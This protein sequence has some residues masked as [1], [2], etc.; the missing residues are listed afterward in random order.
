MLDLE[1]FKKSLDEDLANPN[2]YW[3]TIKRKEAVKERWIEKFKAYA[4]SDLNGVM[5]RLLEKY[6]SDEYRDRE[7]FKCHCE[8]REPFL[9]L[10]F[11]YA[12]RYCEPCDDQEYWND[13]TGAAYYIGDYVIQVMHGQGS[14]IRVDELKGPKKPSLKQQT[15]DMME[16]RIIAEYKKHANSLPNEWAKIAAHKIYAT[17]H[18]Q[19]EEHTQ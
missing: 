2:G 5:K 10:A 1:Q 3:N 12:S 15:I 8:P 13:F 19:N 16:A 6:E 11:E 17:L 18:E 14:V 7:Y 4:E 9:W